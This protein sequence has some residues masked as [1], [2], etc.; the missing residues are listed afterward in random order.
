MEKELQRIEQDISKL[1]ET[2]DDTNYRTQR[3]YDA[4]V[5]QKE[6]G[7][8]G[9][10]ARLNKVEAEV[11]LLK[12]EQAKRA[13]YMKQVTWVVTAVGGSLVAYVLSLLYKL[14]N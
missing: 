11:E 13:I 1:R 8:S 2:V 12:A 6:T 7:V 14:W 10:A 9:Y 3:M 5:G 4:M